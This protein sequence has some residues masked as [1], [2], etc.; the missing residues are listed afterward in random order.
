MKTT[1]HK[2]QI[3]LLIFFTASLFS[4][5]FAQEYEYV[6]MPIKNAIWSNFELDYSAPAAYDSML[7][8]N[9]LFDEDTLIDNEKYQ[10]LFQL[11]DTIPIRENAKLVGYLMEKEKKV[12]YIGTYYDEGLLYDFNVQQGDTVIIDLPLP[13]QLIVL[14]VDT[15]LLGNKKRKQISFNDFDEMTW[16]EGIGSTNGLL[17][18]GTYPL[19]QK[20]T[21]LCMKKDNEQIYFND[22]HGSCFPS[23]PTHFTNIKKETEV[24]EVTTFPNPTNET[25]NIQFNTVSSGKLTIYNIEGKVMNTIQIKNTQEKNIQVDYLEAGIYIIGFKNNKDNTL[26]RSTLIIN[27]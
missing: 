12:Y 19:N 13:L 10:K 14:R 24:K 17:W 16:I 5:V 3:T 20:Y 18:P 11:Y 8:I 1:K 26:Y 22:K 4:T 21:L 2:L 9:A 23:Y 6:P 15:I 25:F 27:K 7:C